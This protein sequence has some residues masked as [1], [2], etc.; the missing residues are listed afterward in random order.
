MF[1]LCLSFLGRLLLRSSSGSW[2]TALFPRTGWSSAPTSATVLFP[3]SPTWPSFTGLVRT[4]AGCEAEAHPR[5]QMF[6]W[7]LLWDA[8]PTR[9]WLARRGLT[10]ERG[11]PWGCTSEETW[12][13]MVSDCCSLS[14]IQVAL[15]RWGYSMPSFSS[16]DTVRE[17]LSSAFVGALSMA[18]VFCCAVYQA[19]RGRN[20]K[21]H[22]GEVVTFTVMAATIVEILSI[23]RTLPLHGHWGTTQPRRLSTPIF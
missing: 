22:H 5:E 18:R 21:V 14:A 6:W 3:P 16:C 2:S 1:L 4:S 15:L 9:A 19:W 13:H 11:C 23:K 10:A 20:A 7:R 17:L 8:I 12:D